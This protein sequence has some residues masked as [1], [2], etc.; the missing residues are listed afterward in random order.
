MLDAA[1]DALLGE[2][3]AGYRVVACVGQGGMGCVYRAE[4]PSIGAQVAIKVLSHAYLDDPEMAERFVAEA[5][6]A[7]VVRHD[8]LVNVIGLGLLPDGRPYQIMEY[9]TGESMSSAIKRIGRLPLGTSCQLV[10]EALDALAALHTRGIV[11]R[12]LKPSNLFITA[13]GR[14]KVIDFGIAKAVAERGITV[15]GQTLGTPEYMAPEQ[16]AGEPVDARADLYAL[17][18]VL[19]EAATG[20]RPF[21]GRVAEA[22]ASRAA[23]P[24][25]G[26]LVAGAPAAL[27]AVIAKALHFERERRY[28]TAGA[29]ARAVRDVASTLPADAFV[30]IHEA[31]PVIVDDVPSEEPTAKVHPTMP[32]TVRG[33]PVKPRA[34]LADRLGKYEVRG[35]LGQ[36]A[37]GVV[38]EGYDPTIGRRVALKVLTDTS[39]A[40]S[41]RLVEEARA[42]ARIA[43]PNVITLYELE[44]DAGHAILVMEL[45]DGLD[46]G[47]WLGERRRAWREIVDVFLDAGRGLVAAHAAGVVHRDFKPSNVLLARDGRARVGDF[48]LSHMH[49]SEGIAGGTAAYVAPEQLEGHP[50]DPRSDQFAFCA[51]LWE[52]LHGELPYA[53]TAALAIAVAACEGK[54]RAPANT[55]VPAAINAILARGLAARR[56]Q[57]FTTMTELLAAIERSVRPARRLRWWIGAAAV[58]ATAGVALVIAQGGRETPSPPAMS[59]AD[60]RAAIDA[61]DGFRRL[62]A[63]PDTVLATEEARALA[64]RWASL[65]PARMIDGG[66]SISGL[67]ISAD[68][69]QLVVA[70][71]QRTSVFGIDTGT[72]EVRGAL[73]APAIRIG[74]DAS[75]RLLA[76]VRD[77]LVEVPRTGQARYRHRCAPSSSVSATPISGDAKASP[78][79]RFVACP[80]DA[81]YTI[82]DLA[83][84]RVFAITGDVVLSR[85]SRRA[86]AIPIGG[87]FTIYDLAKG[88]AVAKQSEGPTTFAV[89]NGHLLVTARD[90]AVRVWSGTET[91][92]FDTDHT[93]DFVAIGDGPDPAVAVGSRTGRV[94][95]WTPRAGI[96]SRWELGEPL[97]ELVVSPENDRVVMLTQSGALMRHFASGR[98]TRIDR[99]SRML[100]AAGGVVAL[101]TT[102]EVAVWFTDLRAPQSMNVSATT[103]IAFTKYGDW[104]ASFQDTTLFARQVARADSKRLPFTDPD[105]IGLSPDGKLLAIIEDSKLFVWVH[106]LVNMPGIVAR[107]PGAK[108]IA[109]PLD[110]ARVLLVDPKGRVTLVVDGVE[111][112]PCGD[113]AML[114]SHR[115]LVVFATDT[116]VALCDVLTQRTTAIEIPDP[117]RASLS[118]DGRRLA[119][120]HGDARRVALF[121]IDG[122]RQNI[123]NVEDVG[124]LMLDE[125]G[126]AI[127]VYTHGQ[128]AYIRRGDLSPRTILASAD[129]VHTVVGISGDG[130]RVGIISNKTVYAWTTAHPDDL[131]VLDR[132]MFGTIGDLRVPAIQTV[133]AVNGAMPLVKNAPVFAINMWPTAPPTLDEVKRWIRMIA[134]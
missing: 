25:V 74:F 107:L 23:P 64:A 4:L 27:D 105:R 113:R 79:F 100:V 50:A 58:A 96:A 41:T 66:S 56:E 21:A 18:I 1:V 90:M 68:A 47:R 16:V 86:V 111:T 71:E 104:F 99:P 93:I 43:H 132:L 10:A 61:G 54:L 28:A 80:Q 124:V 19:Y 133:L 101:A 116:G 98:E 127:V 34:H 82:H 2:V 48:G 13:A 55:D 37:S 115:S 92:Q 103:P 26:S 3:I 12:D 84:D 72:V 39:L 121:T 31:A 73:P 120:V 6:L 108:L 83:G 52:A 20:K 102:R 77:G 45:V 69:T 53:G 134:P 11:H 17:G 29:M 14:V 78:D 123:P 117:K 60:V 131:V 59:L 88:A 33:V 95:I 89:D 118:G 38:L 97:A 119:V 7:N 32:P 46:L 130:S 94:T 76:L 109:T 122:T 126:D 30:A 63:V 87:G 106:E 112:A 5:R 85:D 70:A 128:V 57:R 35:V 62:A 24:P 125:T 40:R 51:S 9:L 42:M 65:G 44:E 67:G 49:G 110:P 22:L 36:G 114:A 15:T 75:G 129:P 81:G 8:G 91:K